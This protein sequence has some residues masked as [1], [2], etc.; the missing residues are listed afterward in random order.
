MLNVLKA[1]VICSGQSTMIN[2]A[3]I[4]YLLASRTVTPFISLQVDWNVPWKPHAALRVTVDKD[5]P[6]LLLPQL[7]QYAAVPK[8]EDAQRI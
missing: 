1:E 2:G 6:R 3:E 5:A 4:D 7:T 8:L